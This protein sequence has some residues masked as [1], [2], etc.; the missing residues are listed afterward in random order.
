MIIINCD[1]G[2]RKNLGRPENDMKLRK[3]KFL[4]FIK[5]NK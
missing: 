4:N 5:K 1:K 2:H 3:M